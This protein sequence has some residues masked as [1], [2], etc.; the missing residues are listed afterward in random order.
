MSVASARKVSYIVSVYLGSKFT[1]RHI[2]LKISDK[3]L[4]LFFIRLFLFASEMLQM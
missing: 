1:C 3:D 4:E 2:L